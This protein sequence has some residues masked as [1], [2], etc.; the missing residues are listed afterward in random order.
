MIT[1][2]HDKYNNNEEVRNSARITKCDTK[3]L[4]EQMQL[5][6]QC[7][8]SCSTQDCHKPPICEKHNIYKVKKKWSSV[9]QGTYN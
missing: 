1:S 5:E 9:K 6:K 3:I 4:S 2:H 8:Q 7:Q